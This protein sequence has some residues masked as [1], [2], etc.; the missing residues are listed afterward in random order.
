MKIVNSTLVVSDYPKSLI[1]EAFRNL[2]TNLSFV[3]K[4][5][6][7][8]AVTLIISG[9]GKTFLVLNLAGI[10]AMSGTKVLMIDLDRRKAKIHL[11]FSHENNKGVSS[12]LASHCEVDEV[13]RGT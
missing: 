11:G 10:I 6:Q 7:T 4:D 12:L 2:R 3:K 9:E 13:L 1:S 8:I 5:V